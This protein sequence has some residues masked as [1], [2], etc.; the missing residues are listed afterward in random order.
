MTKLYIRHNP[1]FLTT[2]KKE[3]VNILVKGENAGNV[4]YPSIN[5][6][7]FFSF[8]F[9]L[10]SANAFDLVQSKILLFGTGL[11]FKKISSR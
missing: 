11:K 4:C 3:A 5:K 8:M 1:N 2:L 9:I 6:F 10:F 7:Q